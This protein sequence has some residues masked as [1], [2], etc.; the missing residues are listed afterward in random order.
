MAHH[1]TIYDVGWM[2]SVMR[3]LSGTVLRLRGWSIEGS[4]PVHQR[5]VLVAAP[6]TSS[7][8]VPL[9]VACALQFRLPVHWLGLNS[10]F[11]W[12][13]RALLRFFGGVPI[14]RGPA[15][16]RVR[17][18]AEL[19]ARPGS[20]VVA[21][22][23]EGSRSAV[24]R[25]RSGFYHLAV[26]AGVPMVLTAL[27]H[28]DRTARFGPVVEPTGDIEADLE[29]FR[30]FYAGVEGRYPEKQGPIRVLIPAE[31]ADAAETPP[32]VPHDLPVGDAAEPV[33]TGDD[34]DRPAAPVAEV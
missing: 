20:M 21:I 22:S 3:W 15:A 19:L 12:P 4:P 9:M 23:P 30:A 1:R 8:D 34:G 7:W 24:P 25:W 13:I 14:S 26:A 32:A 33:D 18:A 11:R 10:Y 27:D 5:F 16:E 28:R 31:D 2:V 29:V 17:D 6:H